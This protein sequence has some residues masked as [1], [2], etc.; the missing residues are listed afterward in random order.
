MILVDTSIWVD[1]LHR[2]DPVL[3]QLLHSETVLVHPVVIGEVALGSLADRS[4]TVRILHK[5]PQSVVAQN[6]EVLQLIEDWKLHGSGIGYSDV[7][8]LA[9][10]LLT[11][12]SRLWTRDRS[13]RRA[14]E[15]LSLAAKLS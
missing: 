10:V 14:A 15:Q 9:S 6:R 5:L 1:H 7:E 3:S 12:G 11:S 4:A 2:T 8:L 13:L